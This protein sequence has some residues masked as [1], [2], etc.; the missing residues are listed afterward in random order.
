ML[1]YDGL[2]SH[3]NIHSWIGEPFLLMS[4]VSFYD[5]ALTSLVEARR[6]MKRVDYRLTGISKHDVARVQSDVAEVLTRDSSKRLSGVDWQ[7]LARVLQDRFADRLPFVRHLAHQTYTNATEQAVAVRREVLIS[8][9]PYMSRDQVGLP[10][11]YAHMAGA[12]ATRYT[13]HLSVS[14]FTKQEHVLYSA[15]REVLHEICR[16]YTDVWRDAFDVEEHNAEIAAQRLEKWRHDFDGLIQWLDWPLWM[17][18]D[19]GCG[20][21]VGA[22]DAKRDAKSLTCP[23]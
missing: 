16:V 4:L 19:P 22:S 1:S 6:S 12:C 13:S 15:T 21:D 7:A 23:L 10:G 14:K 17:G 8:L 3:G 5:P 11:W 20:V 2:A 9:L 18:C